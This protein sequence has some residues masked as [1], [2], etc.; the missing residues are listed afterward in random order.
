MQNTRGQISPKEGQITSSANGADSKSAAT[1]LMKRVDRYQARGN[2][3]AQM[4][5]VLTKEDQDRARAEVL[6]YKF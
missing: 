1:S 4:G 5:C 6:A 3:L 2:M